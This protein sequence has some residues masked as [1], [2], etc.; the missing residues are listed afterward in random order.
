MQERR[1]QGLCFNCNEIFTAG[2]KCT[3][4]Q[5]LFLEGISYDQ[6]AISEEDLE[7]P[8]AEDNI[9]KQKEPEISL[10]ALTRWSTTQ[11]MRSTARMGNHEV[12]VLIDSGSTH[13][14]FSEKVASLLHLEVVPT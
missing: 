6:E 14:F 9:E 3:R 5:L 7:T 13:N 8:V 1:A 12:I 11:T 2:Q 4:P 10:H